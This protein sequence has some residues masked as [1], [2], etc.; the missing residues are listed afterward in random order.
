MPAELY[1]LYSVRDEPE[2]PSVPLH[3][4]EYEPVP[5]LAPTVHAADWLVYMEV[6]ETEQEA[7]SA[8]VTEICVEA[9]RVPPAPVQVT[10]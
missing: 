4:Y 10:V 9:E 7:E 8:G 5:P 1:I 2:S 6:G 3:E